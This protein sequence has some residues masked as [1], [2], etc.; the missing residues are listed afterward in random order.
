M[1]RQKS[2]LMIAQTI[3]GEAF[4]QL[5]CGEPAIKLLL[6]IIQIFFSTVKLENDCIKLY[7]QSFM[8]ISFNDRRS[9]DNQCLQFDQRGFLYKVVVKNFTSVIQNIENCCAQCTL[10][11]YKKFSRFMKFYSQKLVFWVVLWEGAKIRIQCG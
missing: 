1:S 11:Q 3:S 2:L 9:D 4:L 5:Q 8:L 10:T 7:C 6:V